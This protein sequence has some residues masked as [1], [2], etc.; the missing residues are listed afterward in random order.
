[1]TFLAS[2]TSQSQFISRY[3]LLCFLTLFLSV[4]SLWA[5]E[6]VTKVKDNPKF[7]PAL[8]NEVGA[9]EYGMKQY[10]VAFL[11][12]GPNRERS[13]EDAL[14]LQKAHMDNITKLANEGKLVLAGPFLGNDDFRGIYIFD[15]KTVAEAKLLTE[16][17][18]AIKAGSLTM[19]LKPWYGSA[20][21]MKVNQL[22][23]QMSK[24]L[25]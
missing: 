9:D 10:V 24:K 6:T 15:V 19:E 23:Q 17:D 14:A 25:M 18:P 3:R 16:S 2:N 11:K 21:L 13:E 22:H 1:M 4:S 20:A 7:D 5:S 12:R 8:A